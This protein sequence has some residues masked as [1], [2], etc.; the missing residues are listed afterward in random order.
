MTQQYLLGIR[1]PDDAVPPPE[2]L[3]PIMANLSAL[4]E[5]MQPLGEIRRAGPAG[6]DRA[7]RGSADPQSHQRS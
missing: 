5:E 7:D 2:V 3:E 1:Q 4:N 6:S